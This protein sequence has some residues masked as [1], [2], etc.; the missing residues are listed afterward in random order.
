MNLPACP[1]AGAFQNLEKQLPIRIVSDNG[2][3]PIAPA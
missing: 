3:P 1:A 2:F